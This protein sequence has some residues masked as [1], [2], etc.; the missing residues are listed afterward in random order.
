MESRYN[1][2]I[3]IIIVGIIINILSYLFYKVLFRKNFSSLENLKIDRSPL[4]FA[5]SRIQDWKKHIEFTRY[6]FDRSLTV[7][8]PKFF[9]RQF[10]YVVLPRMVVT[11]FEFDMSKYGPYCVLLSSRLFWWTLL[12]FPPLPCS[13][14]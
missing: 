6:V 13:M 8:F 11:F 2:K 4:P 10:K 12:F 5:P 3:I 14:L 9:T 7:L 1:F